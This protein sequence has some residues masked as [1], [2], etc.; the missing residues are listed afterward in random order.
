MRAVASIKGK[1]EMPTPA[2][3]DEEML[4]IECRRGSALDPCGAEEVNTVTAESF[5]PEMPEP[6]PVMKSTFR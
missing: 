2:G 4:S 6:L 3:C 5:P 1:F